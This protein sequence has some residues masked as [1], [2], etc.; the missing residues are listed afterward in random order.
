VQKTVDVHQA[1]GNKTTSPSATK[2]DIYP[3]KKNKSVISFPDLVIVIQRWAWDDISFCYFR[4]ESKKL[5][6]S[7]GIDN[8]F[9]KM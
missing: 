1:K 6:E 2:W 8:P 3:P 5:E 9:V 4:G 7:C